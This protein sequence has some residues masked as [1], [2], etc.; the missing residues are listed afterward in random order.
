L[1]EPQP[2]AQTPPSDPFASSKV[3]R[4]RP[5]ENDLKEF[6][7]KSLGGGKVPSQKQ[8]LDKDRQVL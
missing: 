6:M 4:S 2:E 8:F 5:A 7:E 3:Q 1:N